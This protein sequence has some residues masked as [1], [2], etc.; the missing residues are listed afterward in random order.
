LDFVGVAVGVDAFGFGVG[1]AFFGCEPTVFD[2]KLKA[3]VDGSAAEERSSFG[4]TGASLAL[5]GVGLISE[6]AETMTRVR[7]VSEPSF[8][9]TV[10][11][12]GAT[13]TTFP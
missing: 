13:P 11:R 12:P 4:T 7:P 9:V 6:A 8:A 10:A 3:P 5:C 1:F 2:D